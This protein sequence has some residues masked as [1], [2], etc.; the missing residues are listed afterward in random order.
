MTAEE[1]EES[2]Q[3]LL[4]DP[5]PT[6]EEAVGR[7]HDADRRRRWLLLALDRLPARERRIIEA[8]Q[9]EEDSITLE[10]LGRE[11]GVS[12]ERVRQPEQR[13]MG[14]LRKEVLALAG[15]TMEMVTAGAAP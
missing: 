15:T 5:R 10:T 11:L 2:W 14:R 4:A 1:S 8:R 3:D 6:P 12:K 9:L 13:A 7:A